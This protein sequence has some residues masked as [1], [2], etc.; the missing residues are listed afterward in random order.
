MRRWLRFFPALLACGASAWLVGAGCGWDYAIEANV[1]AGIDSSAAATDAE[2]SSIAD[3]EYTLPDGRVCR[4]HDEDGDG[5][6]DECDN[7]PN[8]PNPEQ[9][10]GSIG[11]SCAPSAAFISTPTRLL[12]DPF[13]SFSSWTAF[14]S[15]A[16]AFEL[17]AAGDA[18]SGG[19]A[20]GDELRFVT[21]SPGAPSNAIVVTTTMTIVEDSA[22]GG[23]AGVVLRVN[24]D[25]KKFYLCA[26]SLKNGFAAARAP[27]GG[28]S[29][30]LCAP[31]VLNQPAP[32]GGAIAASAPVPSDVPHKVGNT[33]GIRAS[34]TGTSGDAGTSGSFECRVFDPKNPATLT[35]TDTK[36]SLSVEVTGSRWYPSG[37]LGLYAQ[38]ASAEF[39]SI[40]VLRGP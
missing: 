22:G 28:C 29:G 14:G 1:E 3:A 16:G 10:G 13:E 17:A 27:D 23:S 30:D 11:S 9:T 35:S 31:L 40:D 19:N 36:Y 5:I 2:D 21:T 4:G 38:K 25:P 7:C 20:A 34:V 15:G 26:V 6:P 39:G 32:D 24:G 12:F 37:D 8:V 33:I 18:V